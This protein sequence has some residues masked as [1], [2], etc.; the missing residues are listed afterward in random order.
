MVEKPKEICEYCERPLEECLNTPASSEM[1]TK[2]CQR[3]R[4]ISFCED[5]N[6][7]LDAHRWSNT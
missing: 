7:M 3:R 5:M 4:A 2:A 1:G 6:K